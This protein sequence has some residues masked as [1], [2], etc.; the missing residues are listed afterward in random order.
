MRASGELSNS[1]AVLLR[2]SASESRRMLRSLRQRL[3]LSTGA[4]AALLGV[5]KVTARSWLDGTR[6]PTGAATRLIWILAHAACTPGILAEDGSW[7]EWTRPEG[8]EDNPAMKW[9]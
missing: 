2:P 8:L 5:P 7:L 6:S 1:M 9:P 4:L 3:G